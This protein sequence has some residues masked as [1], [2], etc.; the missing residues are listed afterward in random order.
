[1][2]FAPFPTV[3]AI[4]LM[5]F[6]PEGL[7]DYGLFAWLIGTTVVLRISITLF[8][9]PH[10]ALGAE[11][12]E[13]Y[14]ERS[15]VMSYNNLLGYTGVIIMHIF[16]WF[17]VFPNFAGEEIGQLNQA[18][19][20]PIVIF[21]TILIALCI[22]SSAYFTKDRIPYLKKPSDDA[23]KIGILDLFQDIAGAL[24]NRN[25]LRLVAGMFFLTLL[26]G[27]HETL[28]IYMGTFF[29]ELSPQQ[30]GL[31]VINNILGFAFGFIVT[32]RLHQRFDKPVIMVVSI[33]M[34]SVFWSASVNLRLLGLAPE[35]SSTEL[36]LFIIFFGSITSAGGSILNITVMSALADIADEHE[37]NTGI[38]QEG[39]F[40]AARTLFAKTSSGIGHVVAGLALD[41][42]AFPTDSAPGEIPSEIIFQLGLIDGPFA[43]IWGLIGAFFYARY[44]ITKQSHA[45]IKAALAI[46]NL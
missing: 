23:S 8:A 20:T 21:S 15:R 31:L 17:L 14:I 27:T 26:I 29:W 3:L 2:F 40:Y 30:I 22:L 35:N 11:L 12:S 43:M 42:I 6:P 4:C 33:I 41:F 18:A 13:D 46:K 10:L 45:K 32:A 37:L 7:S 28:A 9:V 24:G 36:V 25:Y 38:R 19:Y 1:M 44:K 39:V 34:L 16:A 5:F